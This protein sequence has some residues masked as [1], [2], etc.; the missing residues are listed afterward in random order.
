MIV[1]VLV[2]IT[3]SKSLTTNTVDI[4]T[5]VF[6]DHARCLYNLDL[7]RKKLS[8]KYAQ[9]DGRCERKEIF[10]KTGVPR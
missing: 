9:V 3:I 6:K 1:Y 5:E 2:M 4:A 8:E 7:N 10:M